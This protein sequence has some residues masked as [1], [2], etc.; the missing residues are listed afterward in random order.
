MKKM[1][2]LTELAVFSL[3]VKAKINEIPV[4][5]KGDVIDITCFDEKDKPLL[6]YEN[7][8]YLSEKEE[9]ITF[10]DSYGSPHVLTKEG[11]CHFTKK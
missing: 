5:K 4:V 11:I 6:Q 9:I 8:S 2:L 3:T 7:I 1:M 10:K